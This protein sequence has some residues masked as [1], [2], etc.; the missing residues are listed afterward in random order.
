MP[1]LFEMT[2]EI[3]RAHAGSTQMT[4]EEMIEELHK[5]HAA[6]QALESGRPAAEEKPALTVKQAFKKDEVICMVC[7]KGGMK[8]LKRHLAQAHGLKPGQY[9]KQFGI[10]ST[11]SLSARS[12]SEARRRMAEERGLGDVLAKA[13]AARVAK[14]QVKKAAVPAKAQKA[15]AP[16]KAGKAAPAKTVSK[17]KK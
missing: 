7:G 16:T 12:Y 9:R 4:T 8:T 3:V 5:V 17:V 10:P 13:R 15:I 1:T 14:A 2:T 11:Q 6:L